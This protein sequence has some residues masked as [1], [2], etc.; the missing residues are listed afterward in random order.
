MD[1]P[2]GQIMILLLGCVL[3][4]AVSFYYALINELHL[5]DVT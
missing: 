5:T 4:F 2:L 1:Q 3:L